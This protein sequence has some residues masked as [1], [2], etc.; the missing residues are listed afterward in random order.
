MFYHTRYQVL[1][2]ELIPVYTHSYTLT[3]AQVERAQH[4]ITQ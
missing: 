1:G 4:L 3:T 2:P